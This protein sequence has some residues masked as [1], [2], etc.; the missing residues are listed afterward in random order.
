MTWW[1]E[2]C[3][4]GRAVTSPGRTVTETDVVA[5]AALTGD[6]HPLHTNA[7]YAAG[8]EFG[9]RVAHGLLGL[10]ITVGLM[11]RCGL[12]EPAVL[13]LLGIN[14]WRFSAP[15]R[16]GDTIVVRAV[17]QSARPSRGKPDRGIVVMTIE[18]SRADGVVVQQGQ[19][20]LMI[21][22]RPAGVS[23]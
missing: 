4:V 8:S 19:L 23:G 21:A 3:T 18:V 15:V 17:I 22:R 9:Q 6:W 10:G 13:A 20:T 14:E 11:A 16:L 5:F 2:D 12:V 1:F 7:V